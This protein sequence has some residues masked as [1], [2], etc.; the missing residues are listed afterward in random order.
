MKRSITALGSVS[1]LALL[2][3]GPALAQDQLLGL[4]SLNDRIDDIEEAVN[5]DFERSQ[6]ALRFGRPDQRQGMSGS[7]SLG[8]T[9][10]TG[11][12]ES[13]ELSFGTRLTFVNGPFVQNMGIAL[14]FSE[15]D[16]ESTKEDLFAVYEGNYY[17]NDDLYGFVLGRVERD[18]L[19]NRRNDVLTDAFIGVGPGY[20]VINNATTAWRV[21]AGAGVSYLENGVGDSE[22]EL[23]FIASSRFYYAFNENVFLT[24]D[25]DVLTSDAALRINNDLGVNFK[26][27]DAFSTRVSY[28]TE[29]NDSRKTRTDNRLGVAL[30]YGF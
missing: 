5:D 2:L 20:R 27:T 7:A 29:Y 8:Y 19:A 4:E 6:D 23:G 15:E 28:L 16:S 11:N 10:K 18:G 26:M 1:A 30:V 24:N 12:N 3:T 13:Q 17:F 14:D 9:G 25:T 22:T 21:Q